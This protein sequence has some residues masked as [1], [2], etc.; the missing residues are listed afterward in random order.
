MLQR[1]FNWEKSKVCPHCD[2]DLTK[3]IKTLGDDALRMHE[4]LHYRTDVEALEMFLYRLL[5]K[6]PDLT[7]DIEEPDFDRFVTPAKQLVEDNCVS[8][9]KRLKEICGSP[10]EAGELSHILKALPSD[11]LEKEI[12]KIKKQKGKK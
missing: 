6:I 12:E 7:V 8:V 10:V 5:I 11:V 2:K 3:S 9:F 1:T 4:Q